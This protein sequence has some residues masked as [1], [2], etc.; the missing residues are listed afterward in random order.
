MC[1][2]LLLKLTRVSKSNPRIH[3]NTLVRALQ[4]KAQNKIYWKYF[5]TTTK[6]TR[7]TA[8]VKQ[9]KHTKQV[10]L[11]M[12]GHVQLFAFVQLSPELCV[13]EPYVCKVPIM[14]SCHEILKRFP[15]FT[16]FYQIKND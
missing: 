1:R 10:L 3:L 15:N 8:L 14:P 4:C 16:H 11:H 9:Q 12:R 13:P 6:G 7:G 5:E 2:G